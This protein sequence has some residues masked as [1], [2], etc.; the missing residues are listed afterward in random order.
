MCIISE[1]STHFTGRC[2]GAFGRGKPGR[3]TYLVRGAEPVLVRRKEVTGTVDL[4]GSRRGG[5]AGAD[6]RG[7]P[8]RLT[9]LVRGAEAVLTRW[10]EVNRDG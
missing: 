6:G 8:G 3:L 9:Y 1:A 4:L 2:A 7:K 5:C 10:E